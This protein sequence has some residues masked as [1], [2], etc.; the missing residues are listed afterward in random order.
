MRKHY[1][2]IFSAAILLIGCSS[3]QNKKS[4][5]SQNS[6]V[7]PDEKLVIPD[8]VY[9]H[10]HGVALTFDVFKPKKQNGAGVI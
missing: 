4:E 3:Q 6:Q 7:T 8:V 10:K 1:L 2:I 9:G 5:E